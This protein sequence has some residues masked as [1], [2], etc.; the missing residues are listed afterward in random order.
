MVCSCDVWAGASGFLRRLLAGA[1]RREPRRFSVRR[2][3]ELCVAA[4]AL[5]LW[6][7]GQLADSGVGRRRGAAVGGGGGKARWFRV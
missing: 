3:G 4:V 6:G 2:P 1:G 7:R 5:V